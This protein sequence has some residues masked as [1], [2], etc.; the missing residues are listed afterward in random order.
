MVEIKRMWVNQPSK[1][2]SFHNLHGLNVLAVEEYPGTY[3]IYFLTGKTISQQILSEALS[4]GWHGTRNIKLE[5]VV[6]EEHVQPRCKGCYWVGDPK[7]CRDYRV[8]CFDRETGNDF[9][10]VLD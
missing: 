1:L 5:R 2:Q 4:D 3:R 8:P 7:G 10:F 9:I 6:Q